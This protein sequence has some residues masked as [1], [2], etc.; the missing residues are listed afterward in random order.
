MPFAQS[1]ISR[2]EISRQNVGE[3]VPF[4]LSLTPS[5]VATSENGTGYGYTGMRIRGTDMTRINVTVNG[6]P[7]N[8]AESHGV[9]WVNMADFTSS[10][11]NVQIQRGVGT[12]TNGAASFG[13][14]LNFQTL[15]IQEKP[16]VQLSSTIGSFNTIKTLVSGTTGILDSCLSFTARYSKL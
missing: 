8:D 7:L 2:K 4:V 5:V 6:V 14:S 9:F 13:A 1:Q 12:S 16:A 11:D 10:V 3:D 15:G